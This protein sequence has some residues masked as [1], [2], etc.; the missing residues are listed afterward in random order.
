MKKVFELHAHYT[1][2][3]PLS[4][5][6]ELFRK[7]F[8]VTGTY[9]C[10]FLS[11]PQECHSDGKG[12]TR[13]ELQNEKGLFLKRMF[14]PNGYAFAGL[15]HPKDLRYT[16]QT[17]QDFLAQVREYYALGF[18]GIK[19]LEG[20]PQFRQATGV[21]L[22]DE[23]YDL[24]YAFLE[25]NNI[26]ITL[27]IANPVENWDIAKVDAYALQAGRFCG[28]G[29]PSKQALHEEVNGVMTKFP[30]LKLILAHFGFLTYDI[31]EIRKFLS[32]ENTLVDITPG[33]EQFFNM[34]QDWDTWH[35]FFCEYQDRILY[36]SDYY[37]FPYTTEEEWKTSF[38]RRPKFIRQFFETDTEHDYLGTKFHGVKLEEGILDKIYFQNAERIFGE[39]RRIDL[40][41]FK[42]K[43][44]RI[45]ESSLSSA[46][47]ADLDY[48]LYNL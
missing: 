26:P 42:E 34:L 35:S 37:A 15:E 6:V 30:K 33:G 4:E 12:L 38:N 3:I 48:I 41:R 39:P 31:R 40:N 43:C 10:N 20:Y 5:T 32:Y 23:V 44:L 21:P 11:L 7:E 16:K 18:D 46:A 9:K 28:E 36:G 1:F 22:D 25:R 2:H 19:M 47:Q 45:K 8:A 17:R 14:A 27:H 13:R 29:V 24:F